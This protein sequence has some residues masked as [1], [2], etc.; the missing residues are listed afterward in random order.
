MDTIEDLEETIHLERGQNVLEIH[1]QKVHNASVYYIKMILFLFHL[2][3]FL[4]MV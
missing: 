4:P 3:Q 1:I 2:R